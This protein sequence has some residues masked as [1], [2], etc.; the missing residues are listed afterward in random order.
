M[1]QAGANPHALHADKSEME[2]AGPPGS[3]EV[4]DDSGGDQWMNDDAVIRRRADA[5]SS[6]ARNLAVRRPTPE[7]WLAW[8]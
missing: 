6:A 1:A 5:V 2:W 4:E 8:T 3:G 7:Q